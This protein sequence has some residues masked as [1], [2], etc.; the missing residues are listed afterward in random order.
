MKPTETVFEHVLDFVEQDQH[1]AATREQAL[2]GEIRRQPTFARQ[3]VLVFVGAAHLERVQSGGG[4]QG[5]RQFGLAGAG[6]TVE[7]RIDAGQAARRGLLQHLAHLRL[8]GGQMRKILRSPRG[9]RRRF[10]QQRHQ[11]RAILGRG[12]QQDA[13]QTAGADEI[14]QIGQ[15]AVVLDQFQCAQRLLGGKRFAQRR[16]GQ[17]EQRRQPGQVDPGRYATAFAQQGAQRFVQNVLIEII[18]HPQRRFIQ[19]ANQCLNRPGQPE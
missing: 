6:R 14:L 11:R 10:D 13:Q 2:R 16:D 12:F 19:H 18:E 9:R 7:Q 17:I 4:G 5:P 15:V 8:S 1:I 3:P